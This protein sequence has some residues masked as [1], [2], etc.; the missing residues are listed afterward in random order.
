[1]EAEGNGPAG[2]KKA[3][4]WARMLRPPLCHCAWRG[5]GSPRGWQKDDGGAKGG[6]SAGPECHCT[7]WGGGGAGTSIFVLPGQSGAPPAARIASEKGRTQQKAPK[8]EQWVG[9]A[10][11]KKG[12]RRPHG[13]QRGE[14]GGT[15]RCRRQERRGEPPRPRSAS[16][17]APL[18]WTRP[19]L[20]CRKER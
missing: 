2:K 5:V 1:M 3:K 14:E 6:D 7:A 15:E 20:A 17:P 12:A 13:E 18:C 9:S 16:P 10:D 8:T 19:G 11:R 4:L